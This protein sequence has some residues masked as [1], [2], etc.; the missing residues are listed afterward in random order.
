M[1]WARSWARA[2]FRRIHTPDGVGSAEGF[3][4]REGVTPSSAPYDSLQE[5]LSHIRSALPAELAGLIR[6]GTEAEG[7]SG[8]TTLYLA[9]VEQDPQDFPLE[10]VGE[11]VLTGRLYLGN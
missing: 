5:A 10:E 1:S 6:G 4:Y 11:R 3:L 2:R 9:R 7:A 8:A